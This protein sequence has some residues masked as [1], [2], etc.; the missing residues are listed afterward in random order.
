MI[1][2]DAPPTKKLAVHIESKNAA[3]LLDRIAAAGPDG[4]EVLDP[5]E[6]DKA[7]RQS[8]LPAIL[9]M[10]IPSKVNRKALFKSLSK[11]MAKVGADGLV[12]ARETSL[13]KKRELYL[14]FVLKDADVAEVDQAVPLGSD[15]A[16]ERRAI[17]AALE[18]SLKPLA[19]PA[20]VVVEPDPSAPGTAPSD[21]ETSK[22]SAFR[23]GVAG[24]EL[25]TA[26]LGFLD[27]GRWFKYSDAVSVNNTRPYSVFG[28]PGIHVAGELYPG[29]T[30]GITGLR[31]LGLTVEYSQH[32][33]L[34]SKTS[35]NADGS[36]AAEFDGKWNR[37]DLGLRYRFRLGDEAKPVV[38][39]LSAAY[40]FEN[41]TFLPS[42]ATAEKIK[43]EVPTA[44]YK[45]V[46]VGIDG[47]VPFGSFALV[48]KFSYL[49]PLGGSPPADR[50]PGPALGGAV[51]PEPVDD[52]VYS[53]FRGSSVKGIVVGLDG[54]VA[55]GSGFEVRAGFD[56]TR[57]FS[58]F[59]PDLGDAY[60]AGGALDEFLELRALAAYRY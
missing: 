50:I 5:A 2:A 42:N 23:K 35:P 9:G 60:V 49:A 3:A 30:S 52:S 47:W 13:G 17:K 15:D 16:S 27:G 44:R 24:Y 33:A 51:T 18:S 39:G 20:P 53:R 22:E 32:F 45:V 48:P 37:F 28:P 7:M 4:L 29:A 56:Y 34:K 36:E 43:F 26:R 11:A 41:F 21:D 31:D 59:T 58:A 57:Y 46:R 10:G 12:L 54:A 38:L 40:G 1:D 19:P 55:L 25:G 8:G 6:F 14:V